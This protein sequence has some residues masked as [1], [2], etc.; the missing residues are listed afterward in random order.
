MKFNFHN[1]NNS[2]RKS[3]RRCEGRQDLSGEGRFLKKWNHSL[4]NVEPDGGEDV[5]NGGGIDEN[6]HEETEG[7]DGDTK[8]QK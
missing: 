7:S 4:K 3:K 2:K 5:T 8:Q 6:T 1:L